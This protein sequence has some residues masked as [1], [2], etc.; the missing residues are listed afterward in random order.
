MKLNVYLHFKGNCRE[1][2]DFYGKV[3]N[4]SP[5]QTFTYGDAPANPNHPLPEGYGEKIM[6]TSMDIGGSKVMFADVPLDTPDDRV[7]L[8]A[9]TTNADEAKRIWDELSE[10]GTILMPLEKSYFN[11]AFGMLIDKYGVTWNVA[12]DL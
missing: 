1:V 7:T 12:V 5:G 6:H 11:E 2:L 8:V 4:A 10:G 9:N 3:F